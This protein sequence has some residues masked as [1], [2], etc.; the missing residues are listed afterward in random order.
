M[1]LFELFLWRK[2]ETGGSTRHNTKNLRIEF[3][4][5]NNNCIVVVI[6]CVPQLFVFFM[7]LLQILTNDRLSE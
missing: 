5:T 4:T 1:F 2:R 7:L 6:V 3:W